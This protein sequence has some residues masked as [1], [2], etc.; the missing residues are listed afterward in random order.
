M[1]MTTAELARRLREARLAHDWLEISNLE[2]ELEQADALREAL[3]RLN[4]VE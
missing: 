3:R 4:E 1:A 2:C